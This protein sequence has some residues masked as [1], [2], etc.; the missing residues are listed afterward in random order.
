MTCLEPVPPKTGSSRIRVR[1]RGAVQGV[2]FRPFVWTLAGELGLSGWVL[3]D[4]EGVLIEAEGQE[5]DCFLGRLRQDAPPL[6]RIDM[7]ETDRL[8]PQGGEGPF[9]IRRSAKG[10]A[11][12]TMVTPDTATCPA[13]LSDITA[14]DNRRHGYAFTN[15][16][17][18]GPRYTITRALPYDRAQTSMA[19]FPLCPECAEEYDDPSDRRFHAQPN[20]CPV[21]GP[22][23]SM[24]PEEIVSRLKAGE[25]LA[26]KGIGG[27]HLAVDAFNATAVDRLR[28]RKRRDGKPFAVMVTGLASARQLADLDRLDAEALVAPSRPVVIARARQD[29]GLAPGVSNGLSTVGLMLPYSPL[30]VLLFHA[31]AG[32][33]EGTAW[34][35]QPQAAAYVMTSANPGGEPLVTDNGEAEDRLADI[36]DAIVTHDR[37]I[38]VRCDDSVVRVIAGAPRLLRRARGFVP[39]PIR[40]PMKVPSVLAL[41]GQ[42]KSTICV[43]RGDE[44]FVS[45]HI[46]DLDG[47]ASLAFFR[48]TVAHLLEI[49]EVRPERLACDLHPDFASTCFGAQMAEDLGIPLI[50]VQHHHAH[51]AGLVA[52]HHLDGPLLGLALDGFGLGADGASS[53]GGERLVLDG[54]GLRHLGSF[55]KLAQPGGDRAAREPWR[56]GAAALHALARGGE[57]A[58]RFADHRGADLLAAMLDRGVNAPATSSAGRLFDAACGLLGVEPIGGAQT[59][60]EGAAPMA[61]EALVERPRIMRGGWTIRHDDA[62]LDFAP[63]LAVL[64]E[65]VA[66][67]MGAE[68][69]HGTLAEALADWADDGLARIGAQERRVGLSGGCLQNKVL[70]E[71]LVD[72]LL[73][74]GMTAVLPERVPANDGGLSLGQ[75]WVAALQTVERETIERETIQ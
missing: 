53:W 62:T 21:C 10:T 5:T 15:C 41:G 9:E 49:L 55:S 73:R 74:R 51:L 8:A 46:G 42:L 38:V 75:A 4:S 32:A 63:L 67:Q 43:T 71:T 65:G 19:D 22:R 7:V 34:L 57:I 48:E 70:T 33:P 60:F 18:C 56:M 13:C 47:P 50:R 64:A 11:A 54:T 17:H 14:P 39:D 44:A 20:A 30:H 26:I 52:E 27:F 23:L 28:A 72:A 45:Q 3:N 59:A 69:V 31:A 36:A 2:G 6:A 61:L 29:A 68:L 1:V 12:R 16:T 35:E 66:P 58:R 40:L 37:D 24:A 25:I